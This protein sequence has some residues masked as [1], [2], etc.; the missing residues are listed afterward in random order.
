MTLDSRKEVSEKCQTLSQKDLTNLV[1]SL[2][3][4]EEF[5]NLVKFC[6]K[7][8]PT[9][10]WDATTVTSTGNTQEQVLE[11]PYRRAFSIRP[12][13]SEKTETTFSHLQQD[14]SGVQNVVLSTAIQNPNSANEVDIGATI[15]WIFFEVN[16]GAET[17]TNPKIVHWIIWKNP[18]GAL[19]Q[20]PSSPDPTTKRWIVKRGMEMLPKNVSTVTKRIGSVRVPKWMQRMAE[21]DIWTFSYIVTSA[22]TVNVCGIFIYRTFQ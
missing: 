14:S 10:K 11:L 15:K 3:K 17:I 2:G 7:Q 20:T 4:S 9:R 18:Q 8:A 22:K 19:T 13:K 5:I 6:I 1:S 16:L 12:V 21:G